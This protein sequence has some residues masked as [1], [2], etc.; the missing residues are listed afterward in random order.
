[1]PLV[2]S[3]SA[4]TLELLAVMRQL[5]AEVAAE[6]QRIYERWEPHI[7]RRAFR[8]SALNLACYLA[9]RRRDLR[10]L[11]RVLMAHGVSSL[12]RIE[13]RVLPNID[14]V[15]AALEAIAGS[16]RTVRRP[17]MQAFFRGERMLAYHT[18]AAFRSRFINGS[19][20]VRIMVT[21]PSEAATDYA[22]VRDLIRAGMD[23]ARI[24]LAHDSPPAWEAM[25]E[26]VRRAE[27]ELD[28]RCSIHVDLGGPKPRTLDVVTPNGARLHIGD[29]VL[30][31]R[32]QPIDSKDLPFQARCSLPEVLD[33]LQPGQTVWFDD[34]KMSAIVEALRAEGA[35]LRVVKTTAK[36]YRLRAEKGLNFPETHL[37]L[38]PLTT[39]DLRALDFIAAHGGIDM[40]GYSFVQDAADIEDLQR[41]LAVRLEHPERLAIIAKIETPRAVRRLPELIVHAAGKQPF[42][43]MIARGDLAVELG[44]ERMAEMQ[45]E[46]LWVCEA[47]YVPVIWATQVLE[48]Y[49]KKG[50]PSRSEMTDA[51]MA[52]RAECVM[53]NK[54]PFIH[55]AVTILDDVLSRMQEHQNKKT[56]RLRRLRV[57]DDIVGGE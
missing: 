27:R 18:R 1:M 20:S 24:N 5:R 52:V 6:G 23:C 53:L 34:G 25:I 47:A 4:S 28:R 46:I 11:Q 48:T 49:I 50:T 51:A 10:D 13:S 42:G 40:I 26:H 22:F 14:A 8:I 32:G 16:E 41:E 31:T 17:R 33:Q 29:C 12:G 2:I 30:L 9:L 39:D 19:R 44:F 56:P 36:G 54:G 38:N 43:V 35:L 21:F 3:S 7:H 45:E 55:N 15:I 57:W 37:R